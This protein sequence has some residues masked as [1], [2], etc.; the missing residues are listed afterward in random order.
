MLHQILHKNKRITHLFNEQK[1]DS[2]PKWS[3]LILGI[4]WVY[5]ILK[6]GYRYETKD[7]VYSS[8]DFRLDITTE[9][10]F[11]L[12]LVPRVSSCWRPWVPRTGRRT[13]PWWCEWRWTPHEGA[14]PGVDLYEKKRFQPSLGVYFFT[15]I[16]HWMHQICISLYPIFIFS[17]K[18]RFFLDE[19]FLWGVDLLLNFKP[20]LTFRLYK[21]TYYKS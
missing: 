13:W 18:K 19:K 1:K 20:F 14:P 9:C 21:I 11:F 7:C 5:L 17:W 15:I 4:L 10:G 3:E 8:S 12:L 6:S 16:T 2:F